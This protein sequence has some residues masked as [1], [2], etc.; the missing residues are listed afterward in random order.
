VQHIT[1]RKNPIV[2]RYRA[3]RDRKG[4]CDPMLLD[5]VHLVREALDAL[6]TLHDI[7]VAASAVDRPEIRTIIAQLPRVHLEAKTATPAVMAALSP[8]RSPSPIVA[9]TTAPELRGGAVYRRLFAAE[10]PLVV[11]GYNIQD[12]GNVGAIIRAA[13]AA[14]ATG[15]DVGTASADPFG[16]KAVR[17]SMGSVLRLPLAA[18]TNEGIEAARRRGCRIF[19]L[20]PEGGRPLFDMDFR[21]P[22]AIVIGSE[23]TGLP[24]GLEDATDEK[25]TIPMQPPVES[26]NAAVSAAVVL[27]E[28]RRQRS[29]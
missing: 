17:A 22:T 9:L 18:D 13:E 7:V 25:I 1:S 14:G 24:A 19:A 5:G 20:V 15:F 10:R 4:E 6:Y 11:V 26:L 8:V 28:A 23:G 21:G 16:W 3:A 12:P 29:A 27:Y 2:A